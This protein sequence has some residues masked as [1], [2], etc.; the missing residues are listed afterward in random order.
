MNRKE[1]NMEIIRLLVN[2]INMCPDQRFGQVL[3][4]AGVII[5]WRDEELHI[6]KWNN[7]FFEEPREMLTRVQKT[8]EG[9]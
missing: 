6:I 2:Y 3:R 5:D 9:K 4:N 1:A 8:L 7:H